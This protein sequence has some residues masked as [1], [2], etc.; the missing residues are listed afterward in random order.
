MHG[1]WDLLATRPGGTV[2]ALV[3]AGNA[4]LAAT[5]CGLRRSTDA[6]R[7]WSVVADTSIELVA[8]SPDFATDATMFA[9]TAE[10][11]LRS[12]DA[13]RTW[14]P[15]LVGSRVFSIVCSP[16]FVDDGLVLVGTEQDGILRSTD[17]GRT[18]TSANPGLLDLTVLEL[19]RSPAFEVDHVVF[20]ATASGLFRSTNAGRTWRGLDTVPGEPAVQCVVVSPGY[21][22]E[23]IVLAG[24]ESDGLLRSSDGGATWQAVDAF[25]GRSVTALAWSAGQRVAAATD[26]G[27]LASLDGGATWRRVGADPRPVV[28]ALSLAVSDLQSVVSDP[29]PVVSDPQPV[30]SDPQPV[31]S[32]LS[33]ALCVAFA[34]DGTLLAGLARQGIVRSPDL[35]SWELGNA[36]LQANLVVG[37]AVSPDGA[38]YLAGL[39]DG[40]VVSTDGGASWQSANTGLP[41]EPAVFGLAIGTNGTYAAT[42]AGVFRQAAASAFGQAPP[43]R[44]RQGP[45]LR[46]RQGPAS[47]FG[48]GPAFRSRQA[49]AFAEW[50]PVHA[51]PARVVRM[52]GRRAVALGMQADVGAAGMQ[53]GVAASEDGGDTWRT[54]AWPSSAGQPVSLAVAEPATIL[55]GT[56]QPAST[57][58]GGGVGVGASLP[59]STEVGVWRTTNGQDWQRLLLERLPIERGSA[60]LPLA[61]A[62]T[63]AVDGTVFVGVDD[64]VLRTVGAIEE[65]VEREGHPDWRQ[66]VW[67]RARLPGSVSALEVAPAYGRDRDRTILAGT[68]AGVF[69]SRNAGIEFE[70]A[71]RG[72]GGPIV[73]VAFSPAYNEDRLVY[74]VEL[75]GRVWRLRDVAR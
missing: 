21:A 47:A 15:A 69:I 22:T 63:R 6:G 27:V 34:R 75:G 16:R 8:P 46:S 45:V 39:E 3:G 50:L 61:V 43:P 1:E 33:P 25:A 7:T 30:V 65:V 66:P 71:G 35:Q 10:G 31:V 48:Q 14:Q 11:L 54:L 40:V 44:S 52:A 28:S 19:A 20:A 2:T 49:P 59:G 32:D 73:A 23:P 56:R 60:G 62:A 70:S 64:A 53:T 24:T 55:V 67:R 29:Q 36:G 51:A 38:L 37:V 57:E 17:R 72:G 18:W 4:V 13:G 9:G 41:G 42:S 5:P 26:A 12:T 68:T 58:V 74:A